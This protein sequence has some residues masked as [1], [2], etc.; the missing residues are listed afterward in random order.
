LIGAIGYRVS[1]SA[2]RSLCEK[3]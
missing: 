3:E 1:K 2:I